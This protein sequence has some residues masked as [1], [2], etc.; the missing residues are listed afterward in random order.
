MTTRFVCWLRLALRPAPLLVLLLMGA[1]PAARAQGVG[2]GTAV[3]DASAMLDVSAANKG[4]LVP[5]VAL[6]G[7]AAAAPLTLPATGLLVFNTN[8][9]LPGGAGF[10]Y[11]AGPATAPQ[12]V[13]LV[14]TASP[15]GGEQWRTDGN[16]GTAPGTQFVGTSDAQDVV[17]KA[18]GSERLRLKNSNGALWTGMANGNVALGDNT[19]AALT[20]GSSNTFLGTNSG[21][22]TTAGTLNTFLGFESGEANITGEG[23]VFVGVGA[24]KNA[25]GSRNI[26]IGSKSGF[27]TTTGQDNA[28]IGTTSGTFNTTGDL[29]TFF[30]SSSGRD[31]TSGS[32][33]TFLGSSSGLNSTTANE[34]VFV[35]HGSGRA[36]E[37]GAGNTFAGGGSGIA[38]TTGD[39]NTFVGRDSGNQNVGGDL[40]TAL[41]YNAGPSSGALTNTTA[42]GR[43]ARVSASN[44]LVLGGTGTKA[45]RVGIGMSAPQTALDVLGGLAL[46]DDGTVTALTA[47]LQVVTVGNRSYIRLSSNTATAANRVVDLSDGL[48]RGQLLLIQSTSTGSNEFRIGDTTGTNVDTAGPRTLGTG[49]IIMLRWTGSLWSEVSFT[50]S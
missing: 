34:N 21:R 28:F 40:N 33:N 48:V 26:C 43:E 49:D 2:V 6:G 29:N 23:N 24:G 30:G 35:G 15:A 5:R 45:V 31:N 9:A 10:Y 19:G 20:T 13:R 39:R 11:N 41:G 42:I 1:R 36:N 38:T 14:A 47:N 27:D 25:T 8:A 3:P 44:S 4:L 50:D 22:A 12:W 7:P 46:R 17:F 32:G 37:T 18:N 16:A